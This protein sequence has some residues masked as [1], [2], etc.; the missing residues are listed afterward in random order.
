MQFV[1]GVFDQLDERMFNEYYNAPGL[2]VASG[3]ATGTD[4][5]F[6]QASPNADRQRAVFLD[7]TY[8]ITDEFSVSAGVRRAYLAHEGTYVANGPLNG[9]SSNA[10]AVHAERDTAP[11]YTAKYTYA[12]DQMLYASAAKGFRIG[13]T[14]SYLPPICDA[15]R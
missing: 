15:T 8:K 5:E 6:T 4:L 10:Y 1:F 14:N 11:R 3:G 9:G 13:G 12:P 7:T 2:N